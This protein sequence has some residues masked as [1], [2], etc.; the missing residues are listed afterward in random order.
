MEKV[1][2][3]TA[4]QTAALISGYQAG[5]SVESLA[6]QVG[7][8]VRSVIAKLVKEKVYVT[9]TKIAAAA[10]R[11]T[12]A[13]LISQIAAK[14]GDSEEALESLEKATKPALELLAAAL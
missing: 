5:E 10:D 13:V 14:V 6:F 2:N 1:V 7:K 11:V 8:G 3:Y 12:K 9:K 4:E